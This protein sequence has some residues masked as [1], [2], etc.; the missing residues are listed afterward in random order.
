MISPTFY[1]DIKSK[2][3]SITYEDLVRGCSKVRDAS[4]TYQREFDK[5]E[6]RKAQH[7]K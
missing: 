2:V 3:A 4:M 6:K 1:T 7:K 5:T